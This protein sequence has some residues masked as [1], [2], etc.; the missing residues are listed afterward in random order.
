MPDLPSWAMGTV[1]TGEGAPSS[2]VAPRCLQSARGRV[3]QAPG[4][5]AG[6][7]NGTGVQ[8]GTGRIWDVG[9]KS[10]GNQFL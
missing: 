2:V 5:V 3:P 8:E 10:I 1:P 4:D 6:R 7:S 9:E